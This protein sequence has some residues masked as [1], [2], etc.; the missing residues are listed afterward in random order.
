MTSSPDAK[1]IMAD[2]CTDFEAEL[3]E[4]NGEDDHVHLLIH[5]HHQ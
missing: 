4:F 3:F 1:K 5:Y 2:V